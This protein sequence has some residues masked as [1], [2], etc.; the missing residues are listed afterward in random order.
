MIKWNSYEKRTPLPISPWNGVRFPAGREGQA[1]WKAEIGDGVQDLSRKA[2][3]PECS[4]SRN[5]AAM[6]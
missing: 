1:E 2:L 6:C 4:F 3:C 5:A